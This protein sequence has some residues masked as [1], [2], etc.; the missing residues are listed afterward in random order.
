MPHCIFEYTNNVRDEP[1]WPEI[2]LAVHDVLVGTGLFV[3]GDIKSRVVRHDVFVIGDGAEDQAFVTLNIQM[4][5]GR[6][7]AIKGEIATAALAILVQAFSRTLGELK[8]SVT[9]Q[10]SD[11]HRESYRRHVSARPGE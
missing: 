1:Q 7:D 5:S 10:I 4:L 2:I 8:T 9:V 3:L 6:E 11:M